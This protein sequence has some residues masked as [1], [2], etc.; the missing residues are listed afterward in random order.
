MV[1]AVE[2]AMNDLRCFVYEK[3]DQLEEEMREAILSDLKHIKELC[4]SELLAANAYISKL[5][6]LHEEEKH[7][8]CL[9]SG[10]TPPTYNGDPI[11]VSDVLGCNS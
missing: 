6:A 3:V 5:K 10:I 11:V 4:L 9:P 8:S 7:A 2:G 1:K